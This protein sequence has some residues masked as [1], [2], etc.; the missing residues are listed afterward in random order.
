MC[1]GRR[2]LPKIAERSASTW[3]PLA[4]HMKAAQQAEEAVPQC[5]VWNVL[6]SGLSTRLRSI[7][8]GKRKMP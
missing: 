5:G 8:Y 6:K 3:W 7:A 4:R 2:W 1:G